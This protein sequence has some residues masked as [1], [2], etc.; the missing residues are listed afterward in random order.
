MMAEVGADIAIIGAG[1]GGSLCA[2]IAQRIGQKA[3]LIERGSHPRFAIGESSTPI[4]NL[5]LASLVK[6]YDLPRLLPLTKYGT[7][8]K[9]YPDLP[10]GLKR[11]FSFF[12]HRAGEPFVPCPGHS[13]ELLVAAN[14]SDEQGDTHWLRSSLDHFLVRQVQAADIDYFDNTQITS[15]EAGS[16]WTLHGQREGQPVTIHASFVIDASGEGGVLAQHLELP[17]DA[18]EMRTRS[19]TIFGHF[20]SVTPWAAVYSALGGQVND[21]PFDADAAA[22]HH[23]FDGG[24]MWQLRFDHG[25]VSAGFVLDP[26]RFPQDDTVTTEQEWHLWLDRFPSLAQQFASAKIVEPIRRTGRLQRRVAQA[27]GAN[28]AMLPYTAGFVDPLYSAGIAHTL[29]GIERIMD[30]LKSTEATSPRRIEQLQ[31]YDQSVRCELNLLDLLVS[32]SYL[33][34][35]R[36]ELLASFSMLYFSAAVYEEHRRLAD[37]R[38]KPHHVHDGFLGA[39][40]QG[41]RDALDYGYEML[42]K[43]REGKMS[44]EQFHYEI[45]SLIEPYNLVGLCSAAKKNMYD[46][47]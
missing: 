9:T 18:S 8:K 6:K 35:D 28:W 21:H 7:W 34:F 38:V 36:F 31:E 1:F 23:L 42:L 15:I 45:E 41:L 17:S 44:S 13:N 2:L 47:E 4:A 25:V 20:Q 12:Q 24:W 29:T 22:V 30:I 5:V 37:P 10:C 33:C 19:R 43:A 32:G 46:Y 40:D 27:A 26:Q 16:T 3:V 11:G 39:H 14:P